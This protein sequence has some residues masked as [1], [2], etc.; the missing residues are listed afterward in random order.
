MAANKVEQHNS[1]IQALHQ[2]QDLPTFELFHLAKVNQGY[3]GDCECDSGLLVLRLSR[4][5]VTDYV[6]LRGVGLHLYA[7][8]L[9]Y[10]MRQNFA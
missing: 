9:L 5:A 7:Q 2:A 10:Y 8:M 6:H 3:M 1:M 4:H